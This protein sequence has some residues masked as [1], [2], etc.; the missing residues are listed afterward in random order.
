MVYIQS[1]DAVSY[2]LQNLKF[3]ASMMMI[4]LIKL[5]VYIRNPLFMLQHSFFLGT[6]KVLRVAQEKGRQLHLHLLQPIICD[7]EGSF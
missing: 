7:C 6:Q 4:L 5:N 2:K 3:K 1:L